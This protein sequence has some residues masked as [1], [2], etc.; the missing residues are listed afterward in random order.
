M[1]RI[2]EH[3]TNA[4]NPDNGTL[5]ARVHAQIPDQ[6][7]R[8]QSNGQIGDGRAN[9]VQVGDVD[10]NV[11]TDTLARGARLRP[12]PEEVDG[13]ALEDGEEEKDGAHDRGQ[14]HGGVKNVGVDA[15]H[16]DAE[17]GDD[18]RDLGGDTCQD[19][20]ELSNPPALGVCEYAILR[21]SF[22][23]RNLPA[24]RGG[25]LPGCPGGRSRPMSS[26]SQICMR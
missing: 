23:G 13:G 10:Q 8:E 7:H 15:V 5:V 11:V 21:V 1:P 4:Q 24:M 12:V 19:V 16:G 14:D 6:R 3:A 9:T 26:L 25:N 2:H 18:D 17:Q 22:L 20:E